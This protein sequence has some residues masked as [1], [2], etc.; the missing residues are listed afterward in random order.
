M[1]RGMRQKREGIVSYLTNL[2]WDTHQGRDGPITRSRRCT[3]KKTWAETKLHT[4][5]LGPK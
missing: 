1:A 5:P 4:R 2:D 3:A